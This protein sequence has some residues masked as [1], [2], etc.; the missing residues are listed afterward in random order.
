MSAA[1]ADIGNYD[2]VTSSPCIPRAMLTPV[3]SRILWNDNPIAKT[4]ARCMDWAVSDEPELW[5]V[6]AGRQRS[7]DGGE[8]SHTWISQ[9]R[10]SS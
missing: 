10:A 7:G 1:Y 6:P 2:Q 9:Q 5:Y 8:G 3:C 4:V